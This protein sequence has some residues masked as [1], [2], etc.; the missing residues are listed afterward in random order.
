M[1]EFLYPWGLASLAGLGGILFL[2]FYVFRG[3]RIPVS[4]L[5]LWEATR[6]LKREGRKRRRPPLTL[7][8]LLELLAALLLCMIVAG[9]AYTNVIS[10]PHLVVLL[11]SSA[12]MNAGQGENAFRKRAAE[13][14]VRLCR[15]LGKQGRVSIVE[16]G[17]GGHIMGGEP[18][19]AG[20]AQ[21]RLEGW[22][23]TAPPHSLRPAIELGRSLLGEEGQMLLVTDHR[24]DVGDVTAV[25]VGRPMPNTG[26]TAARWMP[27]GRVFALAR[28][29]GDDGPRKTVTLSAGDRELTRKEVDFAQREAV[30]LLFS[31]PDG[32]AAVRVE[33]P[34]DA[35]ANDNVVRLTRPPV[36]A[37]NVQ[38]AVDDEGLKQRLRRALGACERVRPR[39]ATPP[40][41]V[42]DGGGESMGDASTALLR[43]SFLRP[44][45]GRGKPYVGPFFVDPFDPLTRGVDLKGAVWTADPQV[46]PGDGHVLAS[47]GEVPLLIRSGRWL[48]VNLLPAESTIFQMP[49]WPVLVSNLVEHAYGESPG[50]KRFSFRL[51]ESLSFYRP[52]DWRG[53]LAVETPDGG[54]VAFE[55]NHVYYGRLTREGIYRVLV[56]G[57]AVAAV[58]VNL[59]APEESDLT[60]AASYGD[61]G[62]VEAASLRS[63]RSRAFHGEFALAAA[64]LL[65]GCWAL[66]ERQRT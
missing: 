40:A 62:A 46:S 34:P 36:P 56:D 33:L 13:T 19:S 29:F 8:L 15:S 65:L 48:R 47:A 12:S 23:P 42:F 44:T 7:P 20:L 39:V 49:A 6:S 22:R 18:L 60:G 41:L 38:I 64:A 61:A 53:K 16:T 10:R 35:L 9:L 52:E 51:G 21:S 66:L 25:G 30:P 24:A 59:L 4:A 57:H 45:P 5:F 37:L 27:S 58:D 63:A 31:I 43:V 55:E 2:Y 11:D 17:F 3:K 50:L 54:R 26:W 1:L 28:H 32:V 14:I